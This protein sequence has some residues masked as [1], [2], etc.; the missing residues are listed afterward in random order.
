[1]TELEPFEEPEDVEG[2]EVARPFQY[3]DGREPWE[4]QPGESFKAFTAF[5]LY[6]D[7]STTRSLAKVAESLGK[8]VG[9]IERWSRRDDWQ[10]R[11][12]RYELYRDRLRR[13]ENETAQEQANRL[14]QAAGALMVTAGLNR[15]RGAPA[16]GDAGPV[17]ALDP[18]QLDAGDV[19][20]L[21]GEGSRLQRLSLGMA[22]DLVR[23]IMAVPGTDV[24]RISRLLVEAAVLE[25]EKDEPSA[26]AYLIRV[27]EIG[28][29]GR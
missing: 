9:L 27:E 25:L 22:T 18:N 15:L 14:H 7:L 24:V 11:V 16:R 4:K 26:D 8:S 1:M 20:R 17:A 6:R 29:T 10:R 12:E 28:R 5:A 13:E 21:I 19:A 3:A 23:G 2:E